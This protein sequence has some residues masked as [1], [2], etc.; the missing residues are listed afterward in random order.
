MQQLFKALERRSHESVGIGASHRGQSPEIAT[1]L[2]L[3][4]PVSQTLVQ[5]FVCGSLDLG[6]GCAVLSAIA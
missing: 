5:Y 4:K 2:P 1:A 3:A 6:Q